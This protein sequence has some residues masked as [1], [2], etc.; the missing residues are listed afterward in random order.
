MRRSGRESCLFE[1]QRMVYLWLAQ[2]FENLPT[3][4]LRINMHSSSCEIV[5][6]A[7]PCSWI[8]AGLTLFVCSTI[9]WWTRRWLIARVANLIGH[10]SRWTTFSSNLG[11][12]WCVGLLM[13]S[14][15]TYDR[16]W[17]VFVDVWFYHLKI[18]SL[19]SELARACTFV[20]F[21][22]AP[23]SWASRQNG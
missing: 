7:K 14:C 19:R 3:T 21:V 13:S 15:I 10:A 12:Y 23:G 2:I 8:E 18:T 20:T 16:R 22:L 11:W 9:S 17:A 1:F 4:P 6:Y 5:T